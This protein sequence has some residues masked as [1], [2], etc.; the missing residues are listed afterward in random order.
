MG[1]I[2]K[3]LQD[4]LY[5]YAKIPSHFVNKYTLV[6]FLFVIW[7]GIFDTHSLWETFQLNRTI[8]RLEKEKI[9]L[10]KNIENAKS[11]RKDLEN[12]QEKYAREKYYMHKK[13]EEVF[14]IEREK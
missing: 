7:V 12:N 5:R 9:E 2:M 10:K 8:N 14:I 11:D 1:S 3:L 13:N 6:G 4:V